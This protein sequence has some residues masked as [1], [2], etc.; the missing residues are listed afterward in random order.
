MKEREACGG[1][2]HQAWAKRRNS[3]TV[4]VWKPQGNNQLPRLDVDGRVVSK[5]IL[6]WRV[7]IATELVWLWIG[8]DD[9][10]EHENLSSFIAL[11]MEAART[12]ETSVDNY[13][14]R[15]YIPEDKSESLG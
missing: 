2:Q 5:W 9:G 6:K 4:L 7:R 12:S 15:Q 8:Y 11:M 3:Y 13:F 1:G 10:Y 14:A